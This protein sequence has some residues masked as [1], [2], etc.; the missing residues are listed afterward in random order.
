M[1]VRLALAGTLAAAFALRVRG[2]ATQ[3]LWYDEGTSAAMAGRSLFEVIARSAGDIHPPLYYLLLAAWTSLVGQ[4]EYALRFF[5]VSAGM[6]ALAATIALAHQVFGPRVAVLA[7]IAA[8]VNPL[9]IWYAQEARMYALVSLFVVLA[10]IVAV[11]LSRG[12]ESRDWLGLAG[13]VVATA[14][15]HYIALATCAAQIL[16]LL[17]R[18]TVPLWRNRALVALVLVLIAYEPWWSTA[19]QQITGWPS[20]TAAESL[21][22]LGQRI[23]SALWLGVLPSTGDLT[24]TTPLAW[25]IVALG[26]VRMAR[27]GG[28][29]TVVGLSLIVPIAA[30]AVVSGM[31]PFFHPKFLVPVAPFAD[32]ALAVGLAWLS[33]RPWALPL[34]RVVVVI[35][36]VGMCVSRLAAFSSATGDPATRRDDYRGLAAALM[37]AEAPGDV[38]LVSAPGQME[39]LRYYYRGEAPLIEMPVGRPAIED[40]TIRRLETVTGASSHVRGV[41]WSIG[42]VDPNRVLE[43][44]LDRQLFKS[45]DRWF[46]GVRLVEYVNPAVAGVRTDTI[47]VDEEFI[48]IGR[49]TAVEVSTLEARAGGTVPIALQW[50]AAGSTE[51]S[52]TVFAH[53]IDDEDY[54]W[55]QRDS[56]PGGGLRPTTTWVAG[57]QYTDRIGLP[58]LRGTPSG[59]LD[60]EIGLYDPTTGNRARTTSGRDYVRF[61]SIAVR[62]APTGTLPEPRT[63]LWRDLGGVTLAGV[64][65]HRL[66]EDDGGPALTAGEIALFSLHLVGRNPSFRVREARVTAVSG[67]TGQPIRTWSR[68]TLGRAAEALTP[69]THVRV[70]MRLPTEGLPPSTYRLDLALISEQGTEILSADVARL[71]VRG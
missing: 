42:D 62:P 7:G 6:L 43:N 26:L 15:T 1:M 3:S 37:R 33:G 52:M 9:S 50:A 49:L 57:A 25:S 31:R 55:G 10:G 48:G 68:S 40:A 41:L 17:P 20:P 65:L 47:S 38:V 29:S 24:W 70:P 60:I 2:L 5:S 58:I 44:W 66:G 22:A 12:H 54:L 36:A 61:G 45:S 64:D 30:I 63:E 46:G 21:P 13:L 67:A 28:A 11:R 27:G 16:A 69:G 71:S 53:L 18:L 59:E 35:L 34:P 51:R 23:G 56:V 39:I 4:S 14:Y 32:I 8:S 19:W